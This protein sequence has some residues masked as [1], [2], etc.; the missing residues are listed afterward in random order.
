MDIN[1]ETYFI[2][3]QI[4]II[5]LLVDIVVQKYPEIDEK[6][7]LLGVKNYKFFNIFK[8]M[9]SRSLEIHKSLIK[10]DTNQKHV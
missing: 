10:M 7:A 6:L 1:Q 4:T 2:N 8:S 5:L 9:P 3:S